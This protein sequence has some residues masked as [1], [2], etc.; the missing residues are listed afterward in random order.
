KRKFDELVEYL[1]RACHFA[2]GAYLMTG[3]GIIPPNEFTLEPKDVV[4]IS[5]D[6]IGTLENVV[7][8]I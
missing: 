1:Y 4:S 8:V 3:T 7:G 6:G 2:Y 5:I